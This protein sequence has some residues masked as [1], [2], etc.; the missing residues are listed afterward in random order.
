MADANGSVGTVCALRWR[1]TFRQGISCFG[2]HRFATVID[3]GEM[4]YA[5]ACAAAERAHDW[6]CPTCRLAARAR[7]E[8]IVVPNNPLVIAALQAICAGGPHARALDG[9][10]RRSQSGFPVYEFW[11]GAGGRVL[12]RIEAHDPAAAW[13]EVS[14]FSSL[15]LDVAVA[16]LSALAN[17]HFRQFTCAPRR[18]P[19][20]LGAAVVLNAKGY[21]RFGAERELFAAAIAVEMNRLERLR[22]DVITYPG[23]DPVSRKWK[24]DGI[25]RANLALVEQAEH[26][27]MESAND[28]APCAFARPLRFGAWADHWLNSAGL[29]WTAHVARDILRL[30]HRENRGAD[31]LAKRVALMI[32]LSFAAARDAR[33]IRLTPRLLLRRVGLLPRLD[34]A[35]PA[36][37]GRIADRLEEALLRLSERGLLGSKFGGE[38]ALTLR[39]ANRRWFEDWLEAEI[40]FRRPSAPNGGA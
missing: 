2:T 15:T 13:E 29:V 34:M 7:D 30:D 4:V 8:Q 40:I 37:S 33:E 25:T 17:D 36:H 1:G 23:L 24:R 11:N 6:Q 10:W 16:L 31:P 18:E 3:I 38:A 14:L 20:T 27:P 35:R 5:S 22:F 21:R 26:H 12:V 32:S 9:G 39:A 19:V 28:R